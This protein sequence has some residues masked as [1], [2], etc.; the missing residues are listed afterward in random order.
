NY[1]LEYKVNG[2]WYTVTADTNHDVILDIGMNHGLDLPYSCKSGVCSTCQAKLL[3]GEVKMDNNYVLSD[4]ELKQ[5]FVL[6][7][8]SHAMTAEIKVDYDMK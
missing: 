6:T 3:S 1:T 8:Q 7:C 4:K 2:K 5:G